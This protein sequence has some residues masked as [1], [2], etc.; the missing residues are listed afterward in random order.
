MNLYFDC[1]N[2]AKLKSIFEN[3]QQIRDRIKH[4]CEKKVI[5]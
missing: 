5:A 2:T 3:L 1:I 4:R